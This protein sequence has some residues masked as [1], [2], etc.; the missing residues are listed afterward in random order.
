MAAIICDYDGTFHESIRIYAP[1]FCKAY[2]YLVENYAAEPRIWRE[3]EISRWL[4]YSSRDMWN[5]FMPDLPEETKRRCSEIIGSE[6]VRLVKEKKAVLYPGSREVW[7]SLRERGHRLIFLS[8]CKR[9]YMKIHQEAFELEKY[10]DGF[11]CTEDY[12]FAPKY[13]IFEEIRREFAGPYIIIGDRYHD[14]EIAEVHHLKSIGCAYGYGKV[15]EL[16]KAD[17]VA[18][19]CGEILE[20]VENMCRNGD[21][22]F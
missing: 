16:Q 4:G 6:M 12:D 9:N 3:D 8:N 2:E 21:G 5:L 11:Y 19:S 13:R 1:A 7:T 18:A 20:L 17:A 15:D 22:S 10:F 14:M